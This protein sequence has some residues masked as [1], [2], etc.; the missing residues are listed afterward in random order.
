MY[1]LSTKISDGQLGNHEGSSLT[2]ELESVIAHTVDGGATWDTSKQRR[3]R[4]PAPERYIL[5]MLK[6]VGLPVTAAI[7]LYTENGGQG[8]G[9]TEEQIPS[10]I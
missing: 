8:L 6:G 2:E 4:I 9:K 1:F 3:L 5:S 10:T 7:V